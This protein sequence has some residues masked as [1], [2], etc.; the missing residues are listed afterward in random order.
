MCSIALTSVASGSAE[1]N[2][3]NFLLEC[4]QAADP[5]EEVFQAAVQRK[6]ILV[7]LTAESASL[8]DVFVRLTTRE[9]DGVAVETTTGDSTEEVA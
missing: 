3:K 1:E 8:E 6:W 9:A 4:D 2:Q 7:G 5:R